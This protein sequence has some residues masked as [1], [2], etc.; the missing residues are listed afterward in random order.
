[1]QVNVVD[2]Y[3]ILNCIDNRVGEEL[4]TTCTGQCVVLPTVNE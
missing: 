2:M 1:M 3:C 4:E